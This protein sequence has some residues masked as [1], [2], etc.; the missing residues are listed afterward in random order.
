MH[1]SSINDVPRH[2]NTQRDYYALG[3]RVTGTA[4]PV[5]TTTVGRGTVDLYT[6]NQ[7]EVM[8][9]LTEQDRTRL[10][11]TRVCRSC[12]AV[13]TNTHGKVLL[14]APTGICPPCT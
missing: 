12:A 10:Q 13:H 3:R 11:K 14:P 5:A 1:Y 9:G 7:T 2:L 6:L 8:P 4:H